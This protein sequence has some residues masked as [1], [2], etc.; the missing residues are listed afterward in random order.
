MEL[1]HFVGLYL[2]LLVAL[3]LQVMPGKYVF[4][5]KWLPNEETLKTITGP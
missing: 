2:V 1:G 4:S 5:V 3:L